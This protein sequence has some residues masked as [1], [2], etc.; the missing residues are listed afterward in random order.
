MMRKLAP[1][2][3]LLGA[4]YYGVVGLGCAKPV[5]ET[6][7]PTPEEVAARGHYLVTLGGCND[8]HSPKVMGTMGPEPDGSRLLSGHPADM[9]VAPLDSTL[10]NSGWILMGDQ[11]TVFVGHPWGMS[12]ASNLTPDEETGLGSW[13]EQMFIDTIRNG[14]HMGTGRPLLP[15]MPWAAMAQAEDADLKAIFAYLQSLPPVK[16]RVPQ[17]VPMETL[18]GGE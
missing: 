4:L 16:N 2:G 3:I 6:P 5:A 18:L 8:C 11:L 17:P 15:P 14:K 10:A 1:V 9:A 12:Y 13:T 7:A